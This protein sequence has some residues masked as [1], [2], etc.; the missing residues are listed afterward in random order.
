MRYAILLLTLFT[1]SALAQ[2]PGTC[3]RGVAYGDLN[4]DGSEVFARMYNVGT[5][6]YS[7]EHP[8][9]YNG[10]LLPRASP[11]AGPYELSPVFMASLW[12]GGK[13]DGEIRV[14]GTLFGYGEFWPGPLSPGAILPNPLDCS[15]YDRIFVVSRN[16]VEHYLQTGEMTDDLR[17]WPVSWGAPVLDG[18][19]I[20]DNYNLA[21]GDQPSIYGDQTAWW[22]MNDVGNVHGTTEGEPLGVEVQVS[23]FAIGNG[24]RVL[25][26]S[27][28]YRYVIINRSEMP[29]DSAYVS[30]FLDTGIG[31]C[32]DDW[33]GSD[34]TLSMGFAYNSDGDDVAYGI[35][36][37]QGYQ[38]VQ[39][40]IGLPNGR[41]DD[42]DGDVDEPGERVG[43]TRMTFLCGSCTAPATNDPTTDFEYYNHMRGRWNDGTPITEAG[44]GYRTDGPITIFALAGD[45]VTSECWSHT[46]NCEG[47]TIA[48]Q[49]GWA[50]VH[51]GPFYLGSGESMEVVFTMPYA[52]GGDHLDSVVQLRG[53][54]AVTRAAW[55]TGFLAPRRVEAGP[56]PETFQLQVSPPFPNPFTEQTTIRYELPEP[57]RVRMTVYDALGREVA[58]LVDGEQQAGAHEVVFDGVDLAPGT[59]VVRFEA[60]GEERAFTMIKLR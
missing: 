56:L 30:L 20:T 26:Q 18:D 58:V 45:P 46:N 51:T 60:A 52:Q 15:A 32:C 5:L 16:D 48:A 34:T 40:P 39:G 13:V 43:M 8:P 2:T 22:V 35:P 55:D 29:I 17:D 27:T 28:Y 7:V 3:E 38:V 31:A 59:Y 24:N 57:M 42:Q 37:A 53:A 50:V 36:P 54:A 25:R 23:A 12:I 9:N 33:V 44:L 6:F 41:D 1:T 19:G 49:R 10:Y 14:A 21:G 47:G 11:P 4:A